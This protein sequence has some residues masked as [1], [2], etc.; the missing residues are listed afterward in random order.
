M[1][2]NMGYEVTHYDRIWGSF[3]GKYMAVHTL[4]PF[5]T[6]A[7]S[8]VAKSTVSGTSNVNS[9]TQTRATHLLNLCGKMGGKKQKKSIIVSKGTCCAT[10]RKD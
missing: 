9:M 3:I 5:I 4:I 8:T 10:V 7:I 6:A 2:K 1:G